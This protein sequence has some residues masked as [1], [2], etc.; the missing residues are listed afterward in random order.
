MHNDKEADFTVD[1]LRVQARPGET[2]LSVAKR[3]GIR[4]P[5]LCHHEAVSPSGSCRLCVVEVFWGKRSKIVASCLYTPYENDRIETNNG[6]VRMTRRLVL[7]LLAAR[8]PGV[9]QIRELAREYGV[10]VPR[11]DADEDALR[12]RCILCGLCVRVCDEVVGQHAISFAGRGMER[13]VTSPFADQSEECIGC[14]ACVFICPTGAL[15]FE[16]VDGR[17]VMNEL[18]TTVPLVKCRECGRPYATAKQIEKVK[19]RLAQTDR[20]SIATGMTSL[21]ET[22]TRPAQMSRTKRLAISDDA[23]SLCPPCRVRS[24]GV[25]MEQALAKGRSSA[26]PWERDASFALAVSRSIPPGIRGNGFPDDEG[27]R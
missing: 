11:Y 27:L 19:N 1:G 18:H 17:R 7:E 4:I 2:V 6:R 22:S 9:E 25:R 21:F 16:D 13:R 14:G 3:H 23:A 5:T 24:F 15:H 10:D 20:N 8:C 12:E 26:L